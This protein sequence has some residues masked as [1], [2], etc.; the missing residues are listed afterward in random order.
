MSDNWRECDGG[1][2]ERNQ[3][4]YC[5]VPPLPKGVHN[6]MKKYKFRAWDKEESCW[7]KGDDPLL[8][9]TALGFPDSIVLMQF[10]GLTDK[11]GKEIYDRDVVK[12]DEDSI[13]HE[14]YVALIDW[15]GGCSYSL[16]SEEI[17]EYGLS[18]L[19]GLSL[20]VIGNVWENPELLDG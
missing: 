18:N 10:T 19:T 12:V 15:D 5:R 20:E 14:E 1:Y 13:Y 8:L 17:G 2:Y 4:G 3:T 9:A 16:I 11:S 7:I 6:K